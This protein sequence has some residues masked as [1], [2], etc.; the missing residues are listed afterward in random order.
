MIRK[1]LLDDD[2]LLDILLERDPFVEDSSKIWELIET[3]QVEG[4]VTLTTLNKIFDVGRDN[5]GFEIAWEAISEI[6]SVMK[7]CIIDDRILEI[8]HSYHLKDFEQ[9]I[10]LACAKFFKLDYILT[11]KVEYIKSSLQNLGDSYKEFFS[12]VKPTS[13]LFIYFRSHLSYG[14]CNSL[15]F[16][17]I[18]FQY[19]RKRIEIVGNIT[20]KTDI[21]VNY[22]LKYLLDSISTQSIEIQNQQESENKIAVIKRDIATIVRY[23]IYAILAEKLTLD[24][25]YIN[26]CFTECNSL[27]ISR[28]SLI[29]ALQHTKKLTIKLTTQP[30]NQDID[31]SD[32]NYKILVNEISRYFDQFI[33]KLTS[34]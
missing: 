29:I 13:F 4:Y 16:Y 26:S 3:K 7:V 33:I 18:L 19:Y 30:A 2:I 1:V 6:R 12:V 9:S 10:Q 14:F 31:F 24:D 23:I 5:G 32:L 27:N 25:N 28:Q 15:E 11:R 17:K 22:S 34:Y 8:A 20:N 21:L